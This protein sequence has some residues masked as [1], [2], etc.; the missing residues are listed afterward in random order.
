[1]L[2]CSLTFCL[3]IAR[4]VSF[5]RRVN[6]A[7]LALLCTMGFG[8]AFAAAQIVYVDQLLGSGLSRPYDVAIDANGNLFVSDYGHSAVKEILAAGGY[9]TV[10]TLGGNIADPQGLA[11][12]ASDD[13]F[14]ADASGVQEIVAAGGYTTVKTLSSVFSSPQ[15]V[16]VDT[17]GNVFVADTD[18]NTVAEILAS[19]GYT[20]VMSVGS[21]F[22]DPWGVAVDAAGDVFVSALSTSQRLRWS[23]RVAPI[24]ILPPTR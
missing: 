20:T 8:P 22:V 3:A 15:G 9:T 17:N 4:I 2:A 23:T 1:M 14:V 11:V 24:R 7:F 12:D 21:G 19:G 16:A 13:V 18:H 5:R 6:P 10:N